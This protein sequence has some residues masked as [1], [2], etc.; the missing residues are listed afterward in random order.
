MRH[1]IAA[2]VGV[3]LIAA[4]SAAAPSQPPADHGACSKPDL[5]R[6]TTRGGVPCVCTTARGT[7][8]YIWAPVR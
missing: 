3:A 5:G 6:K 2:A 7:A 1:L 4:S 8:V